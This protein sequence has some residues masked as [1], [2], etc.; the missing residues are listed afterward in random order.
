M[1][2]L[3]CLGFGYTAEHYARQFGSRFD[4]I[5]G[6]VRTHEKVAGC[7]APQPGRPPPRMLVFD[8]T[9]VPAELAASLDEASVLLVSVP[10]GEGCDPGFVAMSGLAST[11]RLKSIVYLSTIGVYGDRG[12]AFVDETTEPG[13]LSPRSKARLDAE[14]TWRELGRR[15]RVPVAVLRLAGIYGPGRNAMVNLIEGRARRIVKP[16]Q[17]FNRIHVADIAQAIDAAIDRRINDVINVAD[18]EPAPPQD[19]IAF[20][21][22][23]LGRAPPPEIPFAEAARTMSPMALSF[24]GENKRVRNDK[25]KTTLGVRLRYPTYREGLR[26]LCAA[27]DA[28]GPS[29]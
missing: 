1:G 8:G 3:V 5:V 6:T 26:A 28:S 21:A 10:P 13:P 23:L 22:A 20:A 19:V 7:A 14:T 12:G 24:Y 16:D 15:A 25:L 27:M 4:T 18:D 17:L 9:S 2:I 11:A 29:G